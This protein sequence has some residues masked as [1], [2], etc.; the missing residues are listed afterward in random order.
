MKKT[1]AFI[2]L[3][4]LIVNCIYSLRQ[5]N[6]YD[7][8]EIIEISDKIGEVIDAEERTEYDVFLDKC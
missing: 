3:V 7:R 8:G 6:V 2:V 4:A 1:L 5:Y